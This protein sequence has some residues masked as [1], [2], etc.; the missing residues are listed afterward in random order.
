[1]REAGC[2]GL[3]M[4]KLR[5]FGASYLLQKGVR[6]LRL[7]ARLGHA[8]PQ[9]TYVFT[10][11]SFPTERGTAPDIFDEGMGNIVRRHLPG[12]QP[13]PAP[14]APAK[15]VVFPVPPASDPAYATKPA[16]KTP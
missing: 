6:F 11:A 7:L 2:T 13:P 4:H 1:M 8:D 5:H 15:V 16:T 9:I 3:S 10:L 14:P 12:E